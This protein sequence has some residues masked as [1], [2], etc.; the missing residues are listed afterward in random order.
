ML[1]VIR[2]T[3]GS[4][5]A[6]EEPRRGRAKAMSGNGTNQPP[7]GKPGDLAGL[8]STVAMDVDSMEEMRQQLLAETDDEDK[9]TKRPE[10]SSFGALDAP[11]PPPGLSPL[12][13]PPGGDGG[14][15]FASTTMLDPDEV[16]AMQA[17]LRALDAEDGSA[18]AMLDPEAMAAMRE[19]AS[20][21]LGNAAPSP[22]K[23]K[24]N[25]APISPFLSQGITPATPA[26]PAKKPVSP[27]TWA[28]LGVVVL[29]AI[30]GVIAA[31]AL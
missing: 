30:G 3:M 26:T 15:E 4:L 29:A 25:D 12:G 16:A 17:D 1:A 14:G 2:D 13:P 19:Q 20:L 8:A 18:T 28:I 23:P 21:S 6:W 9:T 7:G 22:A 11:A 27:V 5:E 24:P 10:V 31:V